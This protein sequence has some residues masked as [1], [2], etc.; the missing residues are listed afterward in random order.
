MYLDKIS[1]KN[2]PY[3]GNQELN[4]VNPKTNKP[5]SVIAFVGENACGKTTILDLLFN[6][7]TSEYVIDKQ[8]K[9]D[10]FG[11]KDFQSLF[12]RQNSIHALSQAELVK[13]IDGSNINP[14]ISGDYE[15]NNHPNALRQACAVNNLNEALEILDRFNDPVIKE[16]FMKNKINGISCGGQAL[17]KING[18]KSSLDISKLSSGQQ[19]LIIKMFQLRDILV[20]VDYVLFDEPETSLHPRWQRTIVENLRDLLKNNGEFPQIF[21]ATH[22]EKVLE[23][24]IGKEDVLIFKFSKVDGN[25]SVESL[26]DMPLCLP[27]AT[28]SEINYI[29]FNIPS[30]DYHNMLISR[31]GVLLDKEDKSY[32]IDNYI[33]KKCKND[34]KALKEWKPQYGGDPYRTLPLYIRNFYHHPRNDESVSEEELVTSIKILRALIKDIVDSKKRDIM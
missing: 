1:I 18:K 26:E 31:L 8:C 3:L 29:V 10:H 4:F 9:V 24:L 34:P 25:V 30:Y 6:Y 17:E 5:Y 33:Y 20:G 32:S 2:H 16:A 7:A 12:I 22:S 27:R 11:E 13:S 28:F 21:L 19:E 23:S 14:V 15:S